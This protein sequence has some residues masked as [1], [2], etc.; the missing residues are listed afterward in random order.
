MEH[1]LS[2]R[3]NHPFSLCSPLLGQHRHVQIC[4]TCVKNERF[5][6][7]L[8]VLTRPPV[9]INSITL[10][11]LSQLVAPS[12]VANRQIGV[13]VWNMRD[14][15]ALKNSESAA[16]SPRFI[17]GRVTEE[18]DFLQGNTWRGRSVHC[19]FTGKS[20]C[21]FFLCRHVALTSA[22]MNRRNRHFSSAVSPLRPFHSFGALICA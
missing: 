22:I 15:K 16:L 10:Q 21:Y 5:S 7:E 18:G 13:M 19:I 20:N 8:I 11:V 9:I 14:R 17:L 2:Y 4:S 1:T 12:L 3:P 6:S